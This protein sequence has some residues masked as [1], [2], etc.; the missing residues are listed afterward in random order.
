MLLLYAWS[1]KLVIKH[2]KIKFTIHVLFWEL[3]D[4]TLE[5][6]SKTL[7]SGENN[8]SKW[9]S[10]DHNNTETNS[11]LI[12]CKLFSVKF[13]SSK[14]LVPNKKLFFCL[15][16]HMKSKDQD[17]FVSSAILHPWIHPY[18]CLVTRNTINV[19]QEFLL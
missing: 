7:S 2:D 14:T 8:A 1:Y 13:F 11:S 16:H 18:P 9:K 6:Y 15:V 19:K 3:I 5:N 4:K 10:Y 17:K 12:L